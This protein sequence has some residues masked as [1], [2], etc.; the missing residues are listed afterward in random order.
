MKPDDYWKRQRI[1]FCI[2][3]RIASRMSEIGQVKSLLIEELLPD[4]DDQ[5]TERLYF[6]VIT[7]QDL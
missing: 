7:P 6:T 4:V 3:L 1:C 2:G 5:D